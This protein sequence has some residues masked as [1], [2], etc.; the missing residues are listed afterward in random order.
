M[1]NTALDKNYIRR[2]SV[3]PEW[4]ATSSAIASAASIAEHRLRSLPR[5]AGGKEGHETQGTEL[6]L[7]SWS[8]TQIQTFAQIIFGLFLLFIVLLRSGD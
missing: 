3:L 8:Q 4:A 6:A 1:F 7:A 5:G 2:G